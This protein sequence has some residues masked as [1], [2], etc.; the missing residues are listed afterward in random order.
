MHRKVALLFAL[1]FT[2]FLVS[3][4]CNYSS[5]LEIINAGDP[6]EGITNLPEESEEKV[7][8]D[9][10]KEPFFLQDMDWAEFTDLSENDLMSYLQP[11]LPWYSPDIPYSPPKLV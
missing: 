7:G 10:L 1:V 5:F 3:I 9:D 2:G 6:V 4:S 11:P 8:H